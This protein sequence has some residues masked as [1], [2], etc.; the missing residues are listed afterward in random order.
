MRFWQHAATFLA[1]AIIATVIVFA[2]RPNLNTAVK[3]VA[4]LGDTHLAAVQQ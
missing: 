4:A 3:P 2:G 1:F